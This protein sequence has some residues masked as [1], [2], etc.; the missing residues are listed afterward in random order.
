MV[1]IGPFPPF[2]IRHR[3]FSNVQPFTYDDGITHFE[4]LDC[5]VHYFETELKPWLE[6]IPELLDEF[7]DEIETQVNAALEDV[8]EAVN[9]ALADQTDEIDD[10]IDDLEALVNDAVQQVINS[11][12]AVSDPVIAGVLENTESRS[13]KLVSDISNP[14][15]LFV[16]DYREAGDVSDSESWQRA[17]D[18]AVAQT[19]THGYT[20]TGRKDVYRLHTRVNLDGLQNATIA[21]GLH[22]M[23]RMVAA[24]GSG[25][26]DSAFRVS[27]VSASSPTNT[28]AVLGDSLSNATV[29]AELDANVTAL[30]VAGN[31]STEAAFRYGA[32]AVRV[33]S[34]TGTIPVSGTAVLTVLNPSSQWRRTG[35]QVEVPARLAGV[36]GR[37][38][39]RTA[40]SEARF[41]ANVAPAAPVTV[42]DDSLIT[43][44]PGALSGAG[45]E[46]EPLILWIGRN[47]TE[48]YSDFTRDIDAILARSGVNKTMVVSVTNGSNEPSGTQAYARVQNMNT[49]L[50]DV[51][52]GMFFDLRSWIVNS[53]IYVLGIAP[54]EADLE[55]MANDCPP[56][57]VMANNDTIHFSTA[58]S[59][60]IGAELNRQARIRGIVSP[61]GAPSTSNV[62]IKNF[63]FDGSATYPEDGIFDRRQDNV[64]ADDRLSAGVNM[65]GNLRPDGRDNIVDR[66]TVSDCEFDGMYSLPIHLKGVSNVVIER[67]FIKRS[68]DTGLTFS[69]AV[70]FVNNRV[71]WSSDN[72]VSISRG[73]SEVVI[74]NNNI[75]G[76]YYAGIHVGGFAGDS[77][78][79]DIA[80]TGNTVLLSRQ[81]GISAIDGSKRVVITG[82]EVDGVQR[83]A[84]S[85]NRAS[86]GDAAPSVYGTGI[87]FGG[88]MTGETTPNARVVDWGEDFIVAG[89][90]V[91]NCDRMGIIARG[92]TRR[93]KIDNNLV[94]D[95]GSARSASGSVVIANNHGYYNI[96]IGAYRLSTDF[97]ELGFAS[98]NTIIDTRAAPLINFGVVR[99]SET[100]NNGVN[101][102]NDLRRSIGNSASIGTNTST[103]IFRLNGPSGSIRSFVLESA[104][105]SIAS[106]RLST[107]NALEF[108]AY[109]ANSAPLK[110]NT[111]N[112]QITIDD[113][114]TVTG[115]TSNLYVDQYGVLR[116]IV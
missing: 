89:N 82:N 55:N 30:A 108:F 59:S 65:D 92:G 101:L 87:V 78:P 42:A 64:R 104:G 114:P 103:G 68:L 15:V 109:G 93:F 100:M 38:L 86:M 111:F 105:N 21:G 57:S 13:R 4:L 10:K 58:A 83:G 96:G 31:S 19:G 18:Y 90:L 99:L 24:D 85:E 29:R 39:F 51:A 75:I 79:T 47:S 88:Y 91:K 94:I 102:R 53:L 77:G 25:V 23:A 33:T 35:V 76:S 61:G 62:H 60:A 45:H 17:V 16:D 27:M 67:N 95:V 63:I 115:V 34:E 110:I 107:T 14:R 1:N 12:I 81:Y 3:A 2:V 71:E 26:I 7:G 50:A 74:A 69:R 106:I 44:L 40:S 72:G 97:V 22:S 9:Q 11:T 32:L 116:K 6:S 8:R 70:K 80:I 37:F 98:N 52:G 66:I 43:V 112:G 46:D 113:L 73:C 48:N 28:V 41:V 56:P 36:D 49:Y 5:L 54:T 20:I 84:P